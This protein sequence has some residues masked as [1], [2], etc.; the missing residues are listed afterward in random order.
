MPT[1]D[2]KRI[3]DTLR[4]HLASH[5]KPISFLF[6]SGTS[7]AVRT[8]PAADGTTRPLIPTVVGLTQGCA[9]AVRALGDDQSNIWNLLKA[10]CAPALQNNIEV[11]LS[12]LRMKIDAMTDTDKM[13]GATMC[14]GTLRTQ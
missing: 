10:E 12:R 9:E 3:V 13:L 6:G 1:H 5:E 7:A 11:L 4:D 2:P 14:L 8:T